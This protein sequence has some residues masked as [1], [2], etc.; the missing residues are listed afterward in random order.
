M[1]IKKLTL[2]AMFLAIGMVLPSVLGG[3]PQVGKM[4][5]PMHI[6]VLLC[7]LICGWEYGLTVGVILPLL[8]SAVFGMPVMFPMGVSMA[9]ELGTYGAVAGLMYLVRSKWR[10]IFALYRALIT[11][12]IAGRIV[13]GLV[14]AVL[15]GVAGQPFGWKMFVTGALTMAVPGIIIQLVLIPAL[16]LA[17]HK[18]H[19]VEMPGKREHASA[20]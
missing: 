8:H 2:S 15:Y 5:L 7:G 17:L 10:C 9:C 12:M 4:L 14:S 16:M 6:P 13:W 18:A 19:L 3:I 1:K 20:G 11:A